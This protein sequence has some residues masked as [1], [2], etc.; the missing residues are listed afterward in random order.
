MGLIRT[1]A[2]APVIGAGP[3]SSLLGFIAKVSTNAKDNL[4]QTGS[5]NFGGAVKEAFK[6]YA[7]GF[8]KVFKWVIWLVLFVV[9]AY[10]MFKYVMNRLTK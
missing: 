1:I 6:S 2:E 8:S 10:F 9:L 4:S 3:I 7:T 5:Y